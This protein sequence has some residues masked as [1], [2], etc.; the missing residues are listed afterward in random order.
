[1]SSFFQN[2]LSNNHRVQNVNSFFCPV[3]NSLVLCYQEEAI[4][5][6]KRT[7]FENAKINRLN[8]KNKD[9]TFCLRNSFRISGRV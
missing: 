3:S 7:I 6:G 2:S 5:K 9:L 4:C 8:I 1:M